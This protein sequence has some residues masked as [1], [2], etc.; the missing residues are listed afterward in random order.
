MRKFVEDN[1]IFMTLAGSRMY[2]TST[3]ESDI[4]KRG[5]CIPPKN[6]LLGFANEFEQEDYSNEDTVVF[7]L[8]KF[9]K[10]AS[11]C[12]PNIIEL[13]FA[14]EEAIITTSATWE[15]LKNRR[16]EFLSAKAYHTFTGYA[17]GQLKR[18]R[19]HRAWLLNPPDH[20]PTRKEFGLGKAGQGVRELSKGVDVAEIDSDVIRVIEKEKKHKAAL[21][22]W[23]QYNN[24]KE[25]RNKKR[26]ALEAKHGYDTKHAS[27]LVRL[28]R[29]GQEIL[30]T[31][32][33]T[34]KRPDASELLAIRKGKWSYDELIDNVKPLQD[35]LETIYRERTY[36]VPHSVDINKLSDLCAELHEAFWRTQA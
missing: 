19:T 35:K 12:N 24:W 20:K 33:L 17:M 11:A 31:G 32:D 23:S 14:P 4:D 9:M 8:K 25:N 5:V 28:L 29:M 13:L 18:I 21:T 27:H 30:T 34:V 3:P 15:I 16:D 26:A 2:G 6:V 7:S 22:Y 10:L 36:V 1:L